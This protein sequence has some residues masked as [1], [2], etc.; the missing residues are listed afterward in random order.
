MVAALVAAYLFCSVL[1][2]F[3]SGEFLKRAMKR[4][5][6]VPSAVPE[7]GVLVRWNG[8]IETAYHSSCAGDMRRFAIQT[9]RHLP[10]Y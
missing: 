9:T 4:F 5:V 2:L 7:T 8:Q 10:D 1:Y 3:C 6:V